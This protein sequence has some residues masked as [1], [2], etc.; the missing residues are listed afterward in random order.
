MS[1]RK[2][3]GDRAERAVADSFRARGIDV[4]GAN[5]RVGRLEIDLLIRE[6][7]V[8]AIVEVRTRGEGAYQKPLATFDRKKIERLRRAADRLWADRFSKDPRVA[9][10]RFDAAAVTFEDGGEVKIEHIRAA[11]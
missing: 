8:V 10:I 4:L 3:I 7:D 9:R 5:V 11:F 2:S 6:G 1:S